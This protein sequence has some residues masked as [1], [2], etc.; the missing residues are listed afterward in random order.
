MTHKVS[1]PGYV[2][3]GKDG[4]VFVFPT[5]QAGGF[6]GSLPGLQVST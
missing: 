4:G 1:V 3:V 5:G 2:L 6:F